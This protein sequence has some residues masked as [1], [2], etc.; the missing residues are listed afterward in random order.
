MQIRPAL[1]VT[2]D[3]V[4]NVNDEVLYEPKK[5]ADHLNAY[6]VKK[7][8]DIIQQKPPDPNEAV[9]SMLLSTWRIEEGSET[10]SSPQ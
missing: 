8:T 3:I 2:N 1:R 7:V 5:V 6:Y 4:L 9:L 10:L